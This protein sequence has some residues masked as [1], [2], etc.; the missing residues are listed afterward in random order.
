MLESS[1]QRCWS[2]LVVDS[3][4]HSRG[5]SVMQLLIAAYNEPQRKYHTE[6][7]L[8]ECLS[9]FNDHRAIAEEPAEI[10]M[11]LW[12]HDAI[13]DIKATGGKNEDQSADWAVEELQKANVAPE[14]V[15]RIKDHILATKHSALPQGADQQLLVD[16]DLAIL[17]AQPERFAE[18]EQQVRQEYRHV[19]GLIFNW[20]RKQ[21]LKAFLARSPIYATPELNAR[22]EQQARQNLAGAI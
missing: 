9:I 12:F 10:E 18:Y 3:R 6:Q 5:N 19:P 17:G 13:Y 21:I 4:A 7:H 14:R 1:W 22:F 8:K 2:S 11:A 15:A 20:K 16:I